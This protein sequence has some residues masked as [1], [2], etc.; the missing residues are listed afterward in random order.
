VYLDTLQV[1]VVEVLGTQVKLAA[2]P[3][4]VVKVAIQMEHLVRHK[5]VALQP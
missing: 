4:V 3:V 1:V 2:V 5:L